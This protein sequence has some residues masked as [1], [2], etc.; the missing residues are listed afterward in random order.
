MDQYS[1]FR[2]RRFKRLIIISLVIVAAV[3]F[4]FW[5]KLFRTVITVY[6]DPA[7]HFKYGSIG[8]EVPAGLPYWI[9]VVLPRIFADKLPGPGGYVALGVSWEPG[10]ELPIGFTKE[11]VGFPRVGVNCAGCH[12]TSVRASATEAPQLYLGGATSRF[13][14][15]GYVRFL[16][17]CAHDDRFNSTTIMNAILAIYDMPAVDR[18]LYRYLIIPATKSQILKSEK[19]DY[20][21][22][23]ERPDWGPGRTDMNPF[24]R[25]VMRLPD[26]HT[27]GSTDVMAIWNERA[28]EGMLH[29]SDGLNTTLV[30]SV[31]SAALAAGATKS[32]I[33]IPALDRV[34]NFLMDL[35]A[36][37]YAFAIDQALTAK[38]QPIYAKYCADCHAFGGK[39]TGTVI[40]LAEVGT[41]PNRN[42]HWPQSSADAF[43]KW[44]DGYP[45]AFHHFRSSDG[46]LSVPLEGVW[47]RAPYLHNGSVPNMR[48]LLLPPDQ[49]SKIFYRGYDV[50]DQANMGFVSTGPQAELEGLRYDTSVRGN[51]NQGHT[52]GSDL[53]A[54]DKQA[55]I[56]YLK[57]L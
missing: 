40:S 57:T 16:F 5:Y 36:P 32:S 24:Q 27:I 47:L 43:N 18:V 6:A 31:R 35:P 14:P 46:Y 45:W 39:R 19:D 21:W 30:E 28:H 1:Y 53:S 42:K 51:S 48:E 52:Y 7:E 3:G 37:K 26:D 8:V 29:H 44:A 50:Y 10:K 12:T 56:E 15:Q 17:A 25:Q 22:M 20:Y 49:R 54:A 34:Q 4:F 2:S 41:D 38:G 55:L 23:P 13:Q 11:I 9:W 33:D